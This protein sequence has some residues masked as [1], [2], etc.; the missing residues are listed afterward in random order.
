ME[1]KKIQTLT[2]NLDVDYYNT[3]KKEAKEKQLTLAA[4]IRQ[5]I[6]NRNI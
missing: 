1:E 3:L 5:I 2:V 6:L 4:Y